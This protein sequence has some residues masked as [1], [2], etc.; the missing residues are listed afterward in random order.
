M[1]E[2]I[3]KFRYK[4]WPDHFVGEIL[5]KRWMETAVL[6]GALDLPG[7]AAAPGRFRAARGALARGRR[8]HGKAVRWE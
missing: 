3:I 2:K 7:F 6:S 1:L 8:N 5:A 4:Y